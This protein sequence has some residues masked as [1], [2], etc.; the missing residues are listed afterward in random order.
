M[1]NGCFREGCSRRTRRGGRRIWKNMYYWGGEAER[2]PPKD[3]KL[4]VTCLSKGI[5][6]MWRKELNQNEK[7]G[8][9]CDIFEKPTRR[10][11]WET[12]KQGR[13]A[14]AI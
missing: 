9:R 3:N 11:N 5:G 10:R 12:R 1:V 14:N 8:K 13:S 6:R 7:P 4:G 2:D